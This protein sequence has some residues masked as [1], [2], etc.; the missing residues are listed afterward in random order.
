MLSLVNRRIIVGISGS[1]AAYKSAEIVRLLKKAGAEVIVVMTQNAQSFITPMTMQALSGEPVR[2][3]IM[4]SEAELSMGH[5]ELAKWA[6]A[7]LVAPAS[8]NVLANL[9]QGLSHDL[10]STLCLATEAPVFLAPAMNQAMWGHEATQANA[11]KLT[12]LGYEFFGPGAGEQACGDVGF[13]RLLEVDELVERLAA[14]FETNQL[15]GKKVVISA[16]PT[17]ERIDPVRFLSNYSTGKM[18]YALAQAAQEAGAYV[19]L[20]SGPTNLAAPERV[21]RVLVESA[22]E[23]HEAV[24]TAVA[25]ADV[26]IAA[27]A[28]ADYRPKRCADDK[29][30]KSDGDWQIQ[31]ERNPDILAEVSGKADRPFC[32]G[33]AA[34]TRNVLEYGRGKLERKQLDLIAVNDVSDQAIGFASDQNALMVLSKEAQFPIAQ[35]SKTQVAHQLIELIAQQ[36]S[37]QPLTD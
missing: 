31:L 5:I 11:Q 17:R 21:T 25:D 34:E 16:G 19:T 33:F 18:G 26:F 14:K 9:A 1:I 12:T 36:L 6:D 13:G 37:A 35:A 28:V 15:A 20:V 10:L 29:V 4:D 23:M 2:K 3:E 24:M 7:I 22:I 27:A 8:A 32:V 30:K